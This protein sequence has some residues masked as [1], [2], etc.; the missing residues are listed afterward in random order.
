MAIISKKLNLGS[1]GI[2]ARGT[3]TLSKDSYLLIEVTALNFNENETTATVKYSLYGKSSKK[4]TVTASID[5]NDLKTVKESVSVGT[6]LG[7]VLTTTET[8]TTQNGSISTIADADLSY[9]VKDDYIDS[10]YSI[11]T[12]GTFWSKTTNLITPGK[13]GTDRPYIFNFD[14]EKTYTFSKSSTYKLIFRNSAKEEAFTYDIEGTSATFAIPSS[15]FT[16]YGNITTL[17]VKEYN[18]SGETIAQVIYTVNVTETSCT[19]SVNA[20]RTDDA[21]TVELLLSGKTARAS[22]SRTISIYAKETNASEW[23]LVKTLSPETA[24]FSKVSASITLSMDYAWD[25]YAV[26][27]DGYTSAESDKVRMYSKEYIMDVRTDGKGIAFGGTAVNENE[28]YCGWE[29]FRANEIQGDTIKALKTLTVGTDDEE[30][31]V[32]QK[33]Q[34][35]IEKISVIG[36]RYYANKSTKV[37][38]TG[39]DTFTEGAAI[40]VPPGT[41]V[42]TAQWIFDTGTT[43]DTR[44]MEVNIYNKT[45]DEKIAIERVC[46]AKKNYAVLNISTVLYI[47]E[48]SNL[49]VM[50]SSSIASSDNA[51]TWIRAVRIA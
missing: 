23:T 14:E 31:D 6:S 30:I 35:L 21:G 43:T 42:V 47:D 26:L 18:S 44:N 17:A 16:K 45:R 24:A 36:T 27:E 20:S 7:M 11:T 50:G 49:M 32:K 38:K 5:R 22:E 37:S 13:L 8:I 39:I 48:D 33:L 9:T 15:V 40:T 19:V 28:L 12:N 51:K 3:G 29:T 25:I 2:A 46:A 4:R 34:E 41:Y 10:E 1:T